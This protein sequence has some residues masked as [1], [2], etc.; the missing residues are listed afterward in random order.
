[1]R[2]RTSLRAVR[3]PDFGFSLV[4]LLVVI[5]IVSVLLALAM[6]SLKAARETANAVSCAS[7]LRQQ[8]VAMSVYVENE[9]DR[10]L[11][12]TGRWTSGWG[13]RM[14]PYLGNA[15]TAALNGNPDDNS[16]FGPLFR[17]YAV[18]R[19]PQN[20]LLTGPNYYN[21][22]YGYNAR[23]AAGVTS[24]NAAQQLIAWKDRRTV[25]Q[26]VQVS[27]SRIVMIADLDNN[28]FLSLA[29]LTSNVNDPTS[30]RVHMVNKLNI[31]FLDGHVKLLAED[32]D[33]TLYHVDGRSQASPTGAPTGW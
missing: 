21:W 2:N 12:W 3:T 14:T 26:I 27:H 20:R 17:N 7:N 16:Y 25:S 8:T 18:F 4:E 28:N 30:P 29:Y 5:S 6:P 22:N 31:A 11:P 33:N 15:Y 23:L 13:V 9:R 32:Q 10:A 1:L 24:G 19:C